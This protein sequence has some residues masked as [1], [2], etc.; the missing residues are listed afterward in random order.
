MI[1]ILV[2]LFWKESLGT[3]S[4]LGLAIVGL[5]LAYEHNLIRPEDMSRANTA[6]FTI[7]GWISILLFLSTMIDLLWSVPG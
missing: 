7:N 3:I 2:F 6:F 4:Y 5:L 1:G